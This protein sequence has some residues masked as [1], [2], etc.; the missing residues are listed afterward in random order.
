ME[1]EEG[2]RTHN[3]LTFAQLLEYTSGFVV[4]SSRYL[5]IYRCGGA[6]QQKQ[7]TKKQQQRIDGVTVCVRRRWAFQFDILHTRIRIAAYSASCIFFS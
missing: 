4:V 6:Q 1:K 2:A 3:A 5:R 7:N